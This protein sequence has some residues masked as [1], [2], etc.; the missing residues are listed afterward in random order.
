MSHTIDYYQRMSTDELIREMNHAYWNVD[1]QRARQ[2]YEARMKEQRRREQVSSSNLQR[3]NQNITSLTNQVN[4]L[5][6]TNANLRRII[7]SQNQNLVRMQQGVNQQITDL[8]REYS[9]RVDRMQEEHRTA[10]RTLENQMETA[11]Y[12]SEQE[13]EARM[14][15]AIQESERRTDQLVSDAAN[16]LNSRINRVHEAVSAQLAEQ[17]AQIN[18]LE[19]GYAAL[20]QEDQQLYQQAVEYRDA[21]LAIINATIDYNNAN[22]HNWRQDDLNALLSLRDNIQADL[23]S[24]GMLSIGATRVQARQFFEGA[25]A[26]RANVY[27]D[28]REWQLRQAAAQQTVS[29]AMIDLNASRHIEVDGMDIDVDYWTCGDLRRIEEQLQQLQSLAD[30]PG[31]SNSDLENIGLLAETYRQEI[32]RAVQF[33]MQAR[34]FSF[35]RKELLEEAVNH[36]AARFG[37][38]RP[39]WEEYFAGDERFGYRVYLTAPSGERIVLTAEPVSNA[40]GDGDICNQFRYDILSVGNSIH[41]SGEA[42]A[43]MQDLESALQDLEGC[44]FTTA[45]CTNT[46]APAQDNGQ[47]NHQVWKNPTPAQVQTATQHATPAPAAP[48]TRM[49]QK[50]APF[51]PRSSV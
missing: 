32:Q 3:L 29:E 22:Q 42:R 1:R 17:Q 21:A 12:R 4:T 47:S 11:I 31:T 43:F 26:Y 13:M 37:I 34:Q 50:P 33:A 49:P 48:Q 6:G 20:R 14:N 23:Q 10:M 16:A 30:Q 18:T 24:R 36:I 39:E 35:D 44:R 41:N 15:T 8:Q 5:S 46:A 40:Q 51:K 38:I 27:A 7:E 28:Q 9:Q 19:S 2:V 45:S 25:M